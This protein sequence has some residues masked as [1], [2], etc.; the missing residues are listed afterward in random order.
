MASESASQ[1]PLLDVLE[2]ALGHRFDDRAL[3][4]QAL[5]H[6]S[7]ANERADTESNERLEFLGDAVIGLVTAHLLFETNPGWDEGAL[8]RALH[9]IVDRRGLS[10]LA[11]RLGVGAHLRLGA[12]ERQ[13]QGHEKDTILADAME[14]LIGAVYLDAGLA[15][16]RALVLRE[17]ADA[18]E[19]PVERDPKT[20]FQELVMARYGEFPSYALERDSGIEGDPA[21]F[22]VRA[23]VKGEPLSTGVGRSKQAAEFEAAAR[24]LAR[25]EEA[26]LADADRGA[27]DE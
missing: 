23:Q 16:V 5:Q 21:R 4:E 2:Q 10:D 6:A 1:A 14:A 25:L 8:T 27:R 12:T 9:L 3:L 15:P 24:A 26:P 13:S 18:L 19:A 7:F 22:T 20:Q 17:F 11:R